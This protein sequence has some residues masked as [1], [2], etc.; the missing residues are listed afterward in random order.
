MKKILFV[1]AISGLALASCK[2]DYV[3]ECKMEGVV[4]GEISETLT[5]MKKK[6]AEDKCKSYNEKTDDQTTTCTLK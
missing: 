2:K 4:S 6:E 5:K 3:C 1:V